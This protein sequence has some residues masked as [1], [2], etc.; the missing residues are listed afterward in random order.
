MWSIPATNS[1]RHSTY[2]MESAMAQSDNMTSV[3]PRTGSRPPVGP[4]RVQDLAKVMQTLEHK[5][6]MPPEHL[7]VIDTMLTML[8]ATLEA[9]Y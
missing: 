5:G 7:M 9:E 4:K 8:G 1:V 6:F 2:S 3:F